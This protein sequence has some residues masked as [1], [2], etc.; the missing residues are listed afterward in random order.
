[1]RASGPP[2]FAREG[3]MRRVGLLALL[4]AIPLGA[5]ADEPKPVYVLTWTVPA[6]GSECECNTC[7]DGWCTLMYCADPCRRPR[8]EQFSTLAAALERAN[9]LAMSCQ[10]EMVGDC[11]SWDIEKDERSVGSGAANSCRQEERCS[12][13][14][15]ADFKI[16][17]R[18]DVEVPI[19]KVED[20]ETV[21]VRKVK[22]I[23]YEAKP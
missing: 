2:V 21:E 3:G 16:V 17:K 12:P 8:D 11:I 18:V 15:A 20:S 10:Q 22:S 6:T 19:S 1:M 9:A 13:T 7:K 5:R 23:R 4:V 14:T